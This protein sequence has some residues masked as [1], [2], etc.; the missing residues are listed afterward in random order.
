MQRNLEYYHIEHRFPKPFLYVDLQKLY[1]LG[2]LDG[3]KRPALH[4]VVEA[5]NIPQDR[6][7]H[8][9]FDDAWYTAQIMRQMEGIKPLLSYKSVD[10][11]HLPEKKEEEFTL[12]FKTYSKFVSMLYPDKEAAMQEASVTDLKCNR[13]GRPL[14]IKIDWF[15]GTGGSMYYALCECPKHGPVKGKIRLR[16]GPGEEVFVV[17]TIKAATEQD[18]ADIE[19]RQQSA[20]ERRHKRAEKERARRKAR[21]AALA[22]E[23]KQ[24]AKARITQQKAKRSRSKKPDASPKGNKKGE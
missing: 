15:S 20:Q 8:A 2:Y 3:K 13:C 14:E 5:M 12:N 24:K 16:K 18:V 6:P 10:Y 19:E 11:Y 1:S 17:K 23:N 21:K 9:A 7:F 4:E 22:A